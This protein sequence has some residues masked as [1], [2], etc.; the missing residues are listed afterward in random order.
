MAKQTPTACQALTLS[1][2]MQITADD[3][4]DAAARY[5]LTI[6]L[7]ENARLGGDVSDETSSSGRSR[8]AA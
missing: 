1:H 7:P 4:L 8:R 2:N 3:L 5:E 6:N